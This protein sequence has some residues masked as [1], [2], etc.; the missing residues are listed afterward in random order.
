MCE[1]HIID[2]WVCLAGTVCLHMYDLEE[3]MKGI[4]CHDC[5]C[6]R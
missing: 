2:L 3:Q 5:G 6:G 1:E 4:A